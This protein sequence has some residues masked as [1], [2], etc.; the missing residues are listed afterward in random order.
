MKGINKDHFFVDFVKKIDNFE[1]K[2]I[3]QFQYF[4][5]GF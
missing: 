4:F 5:I 3:V 2:H 1:Q